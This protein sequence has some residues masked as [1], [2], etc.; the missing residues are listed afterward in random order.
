MNMIY[1]YFFKRSEYSIKIRRFFPANKLVVFI[2]MLSTYTPVYVSADVYFNPALLGLGKSKALGGKGSKY[3]SEVPQALIDEDGLARLARGEQLPGVYFV[4]IKLNG[5][6]LD[7]RDVEFNINPSTGKLVP[8]FSVDDLRH[9]GVRLSAF[10]NT[11]VRVDA[12]HMTDPIAGLIDEIPG[13]LSNFDFARGRLDLT[14][15]EIYLTR[16][17]DEVIDARFWDDGLY[18]ALIDYNFSANQ[19]YRQNNISGSGGE[20]YFLSLNNGI[21]LGAWRLRNFSTWTRNSINRDSKKSNNSV[22]QTSQHWDAIN[23]WVQRPIASAKGILSIGDGYTPSDVFDSVQYR[24]IQLASD[25][26]MNND[27]ERSF[28]PVIRGMANSNARVTISQ[29]GNV[30]YQTTVAPGQFEIRDLNSSALSGDLYVTVRESDGTTHSFIQGFSSVAVMQR[31]GQLRYGLT[32]G[33]YRSSGQDSRTPAFIQGHLI[34][35]LPYDITTYGGGL[36]SSNYYAYSI[37]SGFGLGLLGALSSDVTRSH[38][39]LNGKQQSEGE[40]YRIRY[41]KGIPET[42]TTIA[43]AAWRYSTKGYYSFHDANAVSGYSDSVNIWS[44]EV[45]WEVPLKNGRSKQSIELNLTQNFG[46]LGAVSISS[47]RKSYWDNFDDQRTLSMTYS[48]MAKR[49]NYSF[50]YMQSIWSGSDK[51]NDHQISMNIQLP[52]QDWLMG[53]E[54][55]NSLWANYGMIQNSNG[56]A[57]HSVGIGGAAFEDN[58]LSWG[59]SQSLLSGVNNNKY[60]N[61]NSTVNASYSGGRG[62]LSAGYNYGR[63]QKQFSYGLQG[64]VVATR[65][66]V[67]LSQSLGDT[68]ALIRA[69]GADDVRIDNITGARTDWRGYTVTSN[70]QPYRRNKI[71]L[72]PLSAGQDVTLGINSQTVTPTRGAVVLA[73]FSTEVGRQVLFNLTKAGKPLPFGTTVSL[74]SDSNSEGNKGN[75][76]GIIGDAGQVYMSGMPDNGVLVVNWGGEQQ[77]RI[78]YL[79]QADHI[80]QANAKRLP[81][82]YQ[83]ECL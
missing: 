61:S 13:G 38:T 83:G 78:P 20:S 34:Y 33:R 48:V 54:R 50:G 7:S 25:E 37:G 28:A 27:L 45:G 30:I 26:G 5:N 58:R 35:G 2:A 66:G 42:G 55:Q 65:Y 74:I 76:L 3:K 8:T 82:I 59:A 70:L 53:S 21:N 18:A 39:T 17:R 44:P 1:F 31:E 71:S 40:S 6:S 62:K 81:V 52:L 32:T 46:E 56:G 73:S 9:Y 49:V 57:T 12:E 15:P 14:V 80:A 43:L 10:D 60:S 64:G 63:G 67:I 16:E 24:G 19:N 79:L 4:E 23:T 22:N 51:K 68:M 41:S 11:G 72:D 77:C 47:G 75:R 29:N 69:P 36:L